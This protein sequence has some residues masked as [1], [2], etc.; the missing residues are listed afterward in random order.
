M[1]VAFGVLLIA[2][3]NVANLLIARGVVAAARAGACAWPSAPAAARLA[4]LLL[5]EALLA[6][7]RR[8]RGRPGRWPAWGV[9]FL[10]ATFA[11]SDVGRSRCASPPDGRILAFTIA[12]HGADGPR[13]RAS[14]RR[15]AQPAGIAGAGT[16]RPRAAASCANSR[17][18]AGRWSSSRSACRSCMLAAVRPVRA[19]P[20]QPAAGPVRAAPSITS[21][22]FQVSPDASG[23]SAARS[24]QFG[25]RAA[26]AAP[27]AARRARRRRGHRRHPRGRRLVARRSR[28]KA[29]RRNPARAPTRWPTP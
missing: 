22:S 14:S 23:Y 7:R 28:W 18:C 25:R 6:R 15:C 1:A 29:S 26:A 21:L 11:P 19:Q 17:A 3:A 13:R 16:R 9:S 20:R 10:V 2:C 4:W 24:S 12:V 5:A 27:V 8:Q